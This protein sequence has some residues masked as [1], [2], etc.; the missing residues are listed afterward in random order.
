MT[1]PE[2]V[3]LNSNAADGKVSCSDAQARFGTLSEAQCPEFSKVGTAVLDSSV[4][5]GPISGGVYIGDPK[6]GDR[7]RVILAADGFNTH[8]K[9]SGSMQPDPVTGRVTAAFVDLPQTP[10]E[11]F[12]LHF[13]GAERGI[14]ATPTHCGTYEVSTEFTPW[15]AELSKQNAHQFFSLTQG[16]EGAR[17]PSAARP[18]APSF[19]A[20]NTDNTAGAYTP[21][22]AQISRQ[23]GEQNLASLTVDTPPGFIASLKG[24]SYCPE[25]S[26]ALLSSPGYGGIAESLSPS[27]PA[28]SR[29]GSVVA[30][31]G[32]GTRPLH[33]GGSVYLAGPYKGA[34]LSIVVAIPA[35][36]GP[37]DLGN[38]AI[39]AAVF[40]DPVT[41]KVTTVS[42]PLPQIIE[43]VPLRTRSILVSLDRPG[44]TLNPTNC[45][46]RSVNATVGG[47]EGG[48][49]NL[50]SH[51]QVANCSALDY[52]PNLKLSASGGF[53]RRGHPAIHAEFTARP[54][55]ANTRRVTV[56]LPKGEQ[57]DN[58]H[59]ETVC[60]RVAFAAD[61][62]PKGSAIGSA[63]VTTPLLDAPLNG[64]VYLRSSSHRLPDLV[65]DLRGQ[66]DVELS[67]AIDSV[68]G[69]LRASFT[70]VPDALVTSFSLDLLGGKRGLVVNSTDLCKT[71]RRSSVTLKSQN[72]AVLRRQPKVAVPC[73][74]AATRRHRQRHRGDRGG[75]R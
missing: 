26:V 19:Q 69:R 58:S 57:L 16:P 59:I 12:K 52:Q 39:R 13:F 46:R 23:D 35:V 67:A 72:G 5:P 61:S 53:M 7:Y 71:S 22:S 64:R 24:V 36:S 55:E 8:V 34:P 33:I 70:N 1:L 11:K 43:G 27:C 31:A 65:V 20:G 49:A 6:P 9:L 56:T 28:A 42:D 63:E 30:G 14:L 32:A 47:S 73:G 62:C 41:A 17:C 50:T 51:F 75:V 4:L 54:G 37:Y 44:F 2:G 3:S 15:D 10:F 18:F 29:V 21:F 38:V 40:V 74:T 25:G 68:N 45:D 60:T 48:T 66:I